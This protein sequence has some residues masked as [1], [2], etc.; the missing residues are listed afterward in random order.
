MYTYL[1]VLSLLLD[2]KEMLHKIFF[3]YFKLFFKPTTDKTR[4]LEYF[5]RVLFLAP[6]VSKGVDDDTK[7]KVQDY[8]DDHEEEQ[9][10]IDDS[11]SKQ[12]LLHHAINAGKTW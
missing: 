10:V 9:Q 5:L 11:R 12:V 8:D 1:L 7:D 2:D 3:P 4:V 6:E